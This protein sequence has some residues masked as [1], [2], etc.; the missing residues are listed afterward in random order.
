V[1]PSLPFGQGHHLQY[2]NHLEELVPRD[3][4]RALADNPVTIPDADSVCMGI[5]SLTMSIRPFDE[6]NQFRT[7]C[8]TSFASHQKRNLS[9]TQ[10]VYLLPA[11]DLRDVHCNGRPLQVLKLYV[12]AYQAKPIWKQIWTSIYPVISPQIIR[13]VESFVAN[14]PFAAGPFIEILKT[15]SPFAH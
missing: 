8:F 14:T 6:L 13:D 12:A 11:M 2:S 9:L 15:S 4:A 1:N 5:D 7:R 3:V 10:V